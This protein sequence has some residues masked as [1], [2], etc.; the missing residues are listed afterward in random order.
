[1]LRKK[2]LL[3]VEQL[4]HIDDAALGKEDA[5]PRA[6]SFV[7]ELRLWKQGIRVKRQKKKDWRDCMIDWIFGG[8][9]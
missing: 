6:K 1:M 8:E 5:C 9:A 7:E 3:T 4:A 2:H